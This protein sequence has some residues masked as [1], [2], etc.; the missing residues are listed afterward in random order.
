ML[1][2]CRGRLC[3]A[4]GFSLLKYLQFYSLPV[5]VEMDFVGNKMT[6]LLK[7][8]NHISAYNVR[9]FSYLALVRALTGSFMNIISN[10]TLKQCI[11]MFVMFLI[12]SNVCVSINLKAETFCTFS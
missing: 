5:N 6:K 3:L 11:M 4:L 12:E 8:A 1:G 7:R 9:K 10:I 2:E